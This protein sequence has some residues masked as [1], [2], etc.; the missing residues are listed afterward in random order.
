MR[1]RRSVVG[2]PHTSG[3]L[4]LAGAGACT[5][6]TVLT[7]FAIRRI[8]A[9]AGKADPGVTRHFLCSQPNGVRHERRHAGRWEAGTP[10][11]LSTILPG[12]K[13]YADGEQKAERR[14]DKGIELGE[15]AAANP[16][17]E[18]HV[19]ELTHRTR[20][21]ASGKGVRQPDQRDPGQAH[22]HNARSGCNETGKHQQDG[23]HGDG[24]LA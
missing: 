4:N 6:A 5:E 15:P 11:W 21:Q 19:L 13:R 17:E 9:L 23:T 24:G 1:P 18:A 22:R 8:A 20:Q 7:P 3:V 12:Y 2:Q 16:L 10:E 14:I